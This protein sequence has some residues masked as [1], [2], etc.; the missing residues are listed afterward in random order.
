MTD[1]PPPQAVDYNG[2]PLTEGDTVAF[3]STDPISL[4]RGRIRVISPH[5]ICI[6]DGAY[7]VLFDGCFAGWGSRPPSPLGGTV[8]PSEE[9]KQVMAY[10]HVALQALMDGA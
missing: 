5:N 7:L 6:E 1:T 9:A 2:A 8:T 4:R 3:I 10:P